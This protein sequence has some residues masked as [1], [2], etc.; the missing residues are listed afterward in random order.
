MKAMKTF[1]VYD[2]KTNFSKLLAMVE[3]GEKVVIAKNGKPSFDITPHKP[4]KIKRKM[5]F[6]TGLIDIPDEKLVGLD[7]EIQELVYGK[8][9][10]KK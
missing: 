4:E 6:W 1:N 2:A 7:P 5:G 8:D 3:N 9:W 10:D